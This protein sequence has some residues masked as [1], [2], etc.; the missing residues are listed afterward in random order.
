MG[1][2]DKVKD[3][4]GQVAE[5]A[6][7]ATAVGKERLD[8]VRIQKRV[9][10]LYIEIG[11]LVVAAKRGTKPDDFD[12]QLKGKMTE[13]DDLEAQLRAAAAPPAPAPPAPGSPATS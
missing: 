2:L 13:I 5:Q 1:L 11:R 9:D 12:T 8:E 6:K 7:Y 10:D 3:A 4:A